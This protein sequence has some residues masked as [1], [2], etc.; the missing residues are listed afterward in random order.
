VVLISNEMK[1][2]VVC[3]TF[4]IDIWNPG[5]PI[6]DVYIYVLKTL[7]FQGNQC[8]RPLSEKS[9]THATFWWIRSG[10][11][12]IDLR[13]VGLP[14]ALPYLSIFMRFGGYDGRM[15]SLSL[16]RRDNWY[17]DLLKCFW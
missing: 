2:C 4:W 16:W 15:W 3:D 8:S 17:T 1:M 6:P 13:R 14:S 5:R 12:C 7:R 9:F 11:E 10:L